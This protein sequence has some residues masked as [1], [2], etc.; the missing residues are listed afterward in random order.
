MNLF[1]RS[2]FIIFLFSQITTCTRE[3]KKTLPVANGELKSIVVKSLDGKISSLNDLVQ[4]HKASVFYFLMPGCPM[5]ESYR[6]TIDELNE[7]FSG[8]RIFFCAIFSSG[9]YSDAEIREFGL[10]FKSGIPFYRDIDFKLTHALGATVTPEVFV[11]DSAAT[12]LYSG[13]IDNWAYGTGKVRIEATE[14]F[15]NDALENITS[16]KPLAVKS[17]NAY[18][19]IIE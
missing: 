18:G 15:L 16:D 3:E 8:K 7:K 9:Y 2:I 1:L 10:D 6:H 5:C 11:L 12:V 4:G 13:S 17:T 14:F 19:C